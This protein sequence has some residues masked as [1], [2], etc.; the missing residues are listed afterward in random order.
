MMLLYNGEHYAKAPERAAHCAEINGG[1]K[2]GY[3][4]ADANL[5]LK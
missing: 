1:A 2:Q 4:A 5:L 3:G